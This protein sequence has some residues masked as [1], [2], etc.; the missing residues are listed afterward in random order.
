MN[1]Q[2]NIEI[3]SLTEKYVSIHRD[4]ES[5]EHCMSKIELQNSLLV[6]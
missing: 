5:Q 3:S 4:I 6:N 2:K 1:I